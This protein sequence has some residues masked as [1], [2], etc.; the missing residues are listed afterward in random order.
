M[1]VFA[2]SAAD[3]VACATT[4]HR[5]AAV[6]DPRD[7]PQLRIGIS[8][9]EVAQDGDGY[10]GMPIVEAAR[11]ESAASPGQ[12][13]ANAVVRTLVGTRRAL[14]FRDIGELTL[15]G[16]PAPLSAVE[17]IDDEVLDA[18][19]DP[20]S[21]RAGRRRWRLVVAAVAALVVAAAVGFALNRSGSSS[22]AAAST[23]AGV[24]A[25]KGYTPR[26]APAACPASVLSVASDATCG[27][28]VF[29]QDRSKPGGKQ[30]SLLVTSAPPRLRGPTGDPTIDVCGC[31]NLGSSLAREHSKLIHVAIRG[32][33]DSTPALTCPEMTPVMTSALASPSLDRT[34]LAR[35]TD[36]MRRCR[37]RL[38]AAGVD[39]A[40]YNYDTAAHDLLD[41]MVALHIHR[42][43]F[44]AFEEADAEVF[45]VLRQ[46]PAAVRSITLDNPPP[47]GTTLLTDPIGD[48]AGAFTRFVALCDADPIC[49]RGYPD[50][51]QSNHSITAKL[52]ADPQVLTTAN[53]NGSSLPAVRL[54]LDGPRAADGLAYGLS[55]PSAY[56]LIP[57]AIDPTNQAAALAIV[58]SAAAQYDT[59][60]PDAYA[61]WGAQASYAC[62]YGINTQSVQSEALE[63]RTL[64]QFARADAAQW[65]QWCKAW[66]V[67]DVSATLS[68][69][70]VSNVP[71][72]FFRGDLSPDGN[73]N[74]IPTI[75]RGLSNVRTVVF[76]TLGSDLLANG[77]PCLSALRRQFLANPN[78]TLDT[79]ACEKQS[80]PIQFV[81]PGG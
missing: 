49:A 62:A 25:P 64:P 29:P 1:V 18:P 68:Q 47:P 16:I 58:A 24:T 65:K 5:A 51:G 11:L 55:Q 21:P 69:P 30:V 78:A 27:H 41:V 32:Y 17:V 53:P 44:V 52:A 59:P 81:A 22:H 14:R 54:L 23:A 13:L 56:P 79:A 60:P 46:A 50:L 6:L 73:P 7:P 63:A 42:A 45:D 15:K 31:E 80:P 10:S 3:A 76:P 12:T 57:E 35:S 34:E 66:N 43:N 77:P 72:L 33:F 37:A 8:T 70:V 28:L 74:W 61:T 20:T 48:L 38:V 75:A 4:M 67:P 40:Q 71:A 9:G 26:Y 19:A 2:E 36:A 39:P